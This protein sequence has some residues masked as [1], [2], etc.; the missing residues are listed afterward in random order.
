MCGL[1]GFGVLGLRGVNGFADGFNICF[2]TGG[3]AGGAA[4]V[5]VL[6]ELL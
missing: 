2:L 6:V 1:D 4:T 5:L 3:A